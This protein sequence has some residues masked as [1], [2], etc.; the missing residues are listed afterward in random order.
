MLPSLLGNIIL[1]L[2]LA[3]LSGMLMAG[4]IRCPATSPHLFPHQI[5]CIQRMSESKLLL[6]AE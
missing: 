3:A 6:L 5:E 2:R 1:E 4:M